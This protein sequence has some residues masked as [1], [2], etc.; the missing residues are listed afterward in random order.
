[1]HRAIT[2]YCLPIYQGNHEISEAY[3][4]V[5]AARKWKNIKKP[6]G[7]RNTKTKNK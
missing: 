7:K 6:E 5:D 3:P 2:E 4:L 1:L